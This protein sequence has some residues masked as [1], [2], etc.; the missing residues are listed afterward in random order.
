MSLFGT[1]LEETATETVKA[2]ILVGLIAAVS[3]GIGYLVG[4]PARETEETE[5]PKATKPNSPKRNRKGKTATKTATPSKGK[6]A[7]KR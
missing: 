7:R 6:K 5:K 4:K 3:G 1:M 2:G